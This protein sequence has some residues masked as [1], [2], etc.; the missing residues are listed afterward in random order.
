MMA[1][2]EVFLHI[3]AP[4]TGSTFLQ[5]VVF[6]CWPNMEFK[7]NLWLSY[8]LLMK[9]NRKYI[10]SN[11]NLMGRPWNREPGAGLSWSDE[12]RLIIEGLRRLFPNAQVLV[13]FRNHA[14]F[15]LSLY[16]QYLHEG[17]VLR[18]EDFFYADGDFGL[19]KRG[20]IKYMDTI[21]LLENCFEKRPFV[22]TLEELKENLAGLMKKLGN[23]FGECV[24]EL[25]GD[26]NLVR[27]KGVEYW[28]AKLLRILNRLDKKPGTALKPHG[29]LRLTN[30]I[31]RKY[32]L[33]PR[34]LCQERLKGL[35]NRPLAFE[36]TM[37]KSIEEYYRD[38][39][40][41]TQEYIAAHW[42]EPF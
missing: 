20:D 12:R 31:T 34:G 26:T 18:L 14:D 17:G 9:K 2:P 19:I 3:G 28:Q 23:L 22:F 6:P 37:R 36:E 32:E 27:N 21:G 4:K 38:D 1:E 41:A 10:V 35:S 40:E 8:L 42:P 25:N 16:K 11:E 39:W 13:C 24:P 7:N 5:D 30:R 29:L 33:D 15:V